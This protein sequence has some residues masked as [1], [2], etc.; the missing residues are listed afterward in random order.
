MTVNWPTNGPK[1]VKRGPHVGERVRVCDAAGG[2][3]SVRT[4]AFRCTAG[5]GQAEAAWCH[6]GVHS[7]KCKYHRLA[8]GALKMK[9][10]A[11]WPP[12]AHNPEIGWRR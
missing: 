11:H 1:M 5:T 10:Q 6:T 8:A 4:S 9:A 3:Q 7:L 2:I 12:Q